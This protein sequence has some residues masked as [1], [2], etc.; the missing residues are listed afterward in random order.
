MR[1]KTRVALVCAVAVVLSCGGDPTQ[2]DTRSPGFLRVQL[3]TAPTNIGIVALRLT[4]GPVDSVRTVGSFQ[5]YTSADAGAERRVF[6][7]GTLSQG[8]IA[9]FW[10]PDR[11]IA[12]S[13]TVAVD[14][15]AESGTYVLHAG[16]EFTFSITR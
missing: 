8:L 6:V 15:A 3:T 9:E 7:V 13:Y 5:L 4:G 2:P 11:T 1:L 10:V 12:S 14:E 16:G